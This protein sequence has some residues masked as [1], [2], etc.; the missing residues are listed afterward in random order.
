[1]AIIDLYFGITLAGLIFGLGAALVILFLGVLSL[2]SNF[3]FKALNATDR[4]TIPMLWLG[5]IALLVAAI[6][7]FS[8]EELE[9]S[10]VVK[11]LL[12]AILLGNGTYLTFVFAPVIRKLEN[13]GKSTFL[14]LPMPHQVLIFVAGTISAL[15][16]TTHAIILWWE[17]IH[18]IH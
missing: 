4:V 10:P 6:L 14:R 7:S 8:I 15:S 5:G 17:I 16:W 3:W 1:M 13:D 11:L 18:L 2:S 12:T 9:V